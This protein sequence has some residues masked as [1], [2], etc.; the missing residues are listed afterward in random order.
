[1]WLSLRPYLCASSLKIGVLCVCVGVCVCMCV[2]L[3]V[4]VRTS[5][6]IWERRVTH[7]FVFLEQVAT[8]KTVRVCKG[9]AEVLEGLRPTK[10]FSTPQESTCLCPPCAPARAAGGYSHCHVSFPSHLMLCHSWC[11]TRRGQDPHPHGPHGSFSLQVFFMPFLMSGMLG[12]KFSS[13]SRCRHHHHHQRRFVPYNRQH[14]SFL[15]S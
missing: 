13:H 9:A 6:V 14:S 12:T 5:L 4:C 8:A 3:C 7:T 2:C 11:L 1:M 10:F 15:F